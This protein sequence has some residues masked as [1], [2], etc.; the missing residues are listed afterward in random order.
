MRLLRFL[1]TREGYGENYGSS[2]GLH[3]DRNG[4]NSQEI[5]PMTRLCF[6]LVLAIVILTVCHTGVRADDIICQFR[7]GSNDG[8]IRV[9]ADNARCPRG[10]RRAVRVRDIFGAPTGGLRVRSAVTILDNLRTTFRNITVDEGAT[11]RVHSGTRLRC[12]G[13]VTINGALEVLSGAAGAVR[14]IQSDISLLLVP[15]ILPAHPGASFQV[16][17]SGAITTSQTTP[18]TSSRQFVGKDPFGAITIKPGQFGGGG[19]GAGTGV[20]GLG[21]G[22]LLIVAGGAITNNGTI[23]AEGSDA[24]GGGLLGN[25]NGGGA[26]GIIVLAA[27]RRISNNGT[28]SVSGGDGSSSSNESGIAVAPGGGGAGGYINL[29]APRIRNNNTVRFSGGAAG[30]LDEDS[31]TGASLFV[32]GASGGSLFGVG[33]RGGSI[34]SSVISAAEDGSVGHFDTLTLSAKAVLDSF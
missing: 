24:V 7:S 17:A 28:I 2:T 25:G 23:S 18:V 6:S 29:I 16:A 33:G 15:S 8:D 11:L 19:G 31:A 4:K 20:G 1:R 22:S 3:I 5:P 12:T 10:S 27:Q 34:N 32:A 13:D 21:G 26:G 14:E 9:V 30:S